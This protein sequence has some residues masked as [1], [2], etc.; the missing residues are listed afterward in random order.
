MDDDDVRLIELCGGFTLAD[1]AKVAAAVGKEVPV[2]H[3]T[4]AVDS[5][6]GTAAYAAAFEAVAQ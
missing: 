5:V 4:F 1:A 3:V 2:G 6:P